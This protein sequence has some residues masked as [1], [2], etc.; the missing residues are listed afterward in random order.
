MTHPLIVIGGATGSGKTALAL[1][2]AHTHPQCVI[3]SADSR[4]IYARLDI[5]SA[6]V[7]EKGIDTTLTGKSEPVWIAEGIPQFLID[8]AAPNKDFTLADYQREAYRLI[9]ACWENNKVPVLVGGTGLYLQAVSEGYDPG[10]EPDKHLRET[11][12][13]LPLD[14]LL[15]KLHTLGGTIVET[16]AQNKRRIIRAIERVMHSH[17]RIEKRPITDNV[18][19]FVVDRDWE[20]QRGLA[21]AMVQDHL[22]KGLVAETEQLLA[23]GVERDWLYSMGLSYRLV[24]DMLDGKFPE[25]ELSIRMVHAFRQLMR[26]QRAWFN[27]MPQSQKLPASDIEQAV[28]TLLSD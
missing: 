12:E 7:G 21:P 19:V 11:L 18:H 23:T 22:D 14:D 4:Q 28:A 17:G 10:G 20:E 26:R 27:R 1:R 24:M 15:E 25:S 5:G 16:D 8:I 13:S 9:S 3:L 6:K 2:I